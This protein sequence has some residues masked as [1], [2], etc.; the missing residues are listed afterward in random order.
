DLSKRQL[1]IAGH[2][3]L[4]LSADWQEA[5]RQAVESGSGFINLDSDPDIG[6]NAHMQA[7]FAAAGSTLGTAA[8]AV[9]VPA[10]VASGG[11]NAHYIAALQTKFLGDPPGDFVYSFHPDDDVILRSAAATVLAG[12]QGT[13]IARLGDDPLILAAVYQSGRAV[14]WGTYD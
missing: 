12:A 7:I 9:T 8:T 1:I 14:H 6:Y 4:N 10:D 5:I 13:V 3:G 2:T 11:S